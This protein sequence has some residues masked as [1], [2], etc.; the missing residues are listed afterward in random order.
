MNRKNA[1]TSIPLILN[2]LI[3]LTGLSALVSEGAEEAQDN[4]KNAE[5]VRDAA[6]LY[7]QGLAEL[8]T[9]NLAAAVDLLEA[10]TAKEPDNLLYGTD[11]RQ[12][13]IAA[14]GDEAELYDRCL[15]FFQDLVKQY[16]DA[17]TA[18]LNLAFAHVDKIPVEGSITQVILAH[19]SIGHFTS[20]LELEETWLGL[21]SRGRAYLFWPPIFGYTQDGINDLERAV[22]LSQEAE[23]SRPHY[24]RAW[25][26]LG[27]GHWRLDDVETAR[28]IWAQGREVFPNNP[29]LE[30][31]LS[32]T[33][34]AELDT[35]LEAVFDTTQRVGTHL[36][37]IYGLRESPLDESETTP[38]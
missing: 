4:T 15:E 11:Y 30:A 5:D 18:F 1:K 3:L 6:T 7:Q 29:E 19:T 31:R 25:A 13:V 21:F 10:A 27:D 33:E 38:E 9:K 35:F 36:E 8:S 26:A 12:A 14:A 2:L 23:A 20:A 37:E 16:P 17:P 28:A 24:A 22:Q 34:R 32:R